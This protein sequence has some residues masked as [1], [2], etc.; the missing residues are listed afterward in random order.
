MDSSL[1]R[2]E[3]MPGHRASRVFLCVCLHVPY[4]LPSLSLSSPPSRP[5]LHLD[6]HR[7]C[8]V[9]L[10]AEAARGGPE[11]LPEPEVADVGGGARG[12]AQLL[13]R[14]RDLG[15]RPAA[16]EEEGRDGA[17]GEGPGPALRAGRAR[18]GYEH[19][20]N[21]ERVLR[22]GEDLGRGEEGEGGVVD[23]GDEVGADEERGRNDAPGK[24][25]RLLLRVGE[26]RV[27]DLN[28]KCERRGV[29]GREEGK[30]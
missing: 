21:A 24:E 9:Q 30:G 23:A 20:L 16:V 19:P 14:A 12:E 4:L 26:A 27:A 10:R 17:V 7:A 28:G 25:V 5:L 2:H 29:G 11:V 1:V 6:E 15:R 3:Q 18:G 8:P 22:D 13:P